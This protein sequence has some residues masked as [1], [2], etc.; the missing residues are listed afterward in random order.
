MTDDSRE[1]G[2]IKGIKISPS[3]ALTHLLF[4]DDAILLGTSTLP[5]WISFDVILK[6]FCKASGMTISIDKS[7]FLFNNVNSDTLGDIARVLSYKIEPITSGFKYIGFYLKPLGYKVRDWN[8][9]ILKYEKRI[10]NWSHKLL[11]LGGRLTLV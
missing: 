10:Y 2:L 1:P 11:S 3:L 6:A 5:E 9:L 7:S 4:M 8:W